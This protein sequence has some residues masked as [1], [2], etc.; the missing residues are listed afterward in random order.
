MGRPTY[1]PGPR[2]LSSWVLLAE[3]GY[4]LDPR[5][6]NRTGR[7]A[8]ASTGTIGVHRRRKTNRC[9]LRVPIR[10][11]AERPMAIGVEGVQYG[12]CR[13][14]TGALGGKVNMTQGLFI[15]GARP[16]SKKAVK[17]AVAHAPETIRV[18]GTSMFGGDYDGPLT[19]APDG[20]IDFVGPDPYRARNFY[21]N[22][23]VKGGV[24]K[25]T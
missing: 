5:R 23:N 25:V 9:N 11:R 3:Y 7:M 1:S 16:K 13:S 6:L 22:L 17:E 19:E 18:E 24:I 4:R 20:R 10:S 21:G 15:D 8:T 12:V 14:A 2:D